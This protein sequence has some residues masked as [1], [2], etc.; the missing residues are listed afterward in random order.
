MSVTNGEPFGRS[1]ALASAAE[2]SAAAVSSAGIS[3]AGLG[4]AEISG[5]PQFAA[6][7]ATPA[8]WG[9]VA[10]VCL[11]VA[12]VA[13]AQAQPVIAPP[14]QPELPKATAPPQAVA[15]TAEGE[16]GA[17]R[18]ETGLGVV[19][20]FLRDPLTWGPVHVHPRAAYRF[21][22]GNGISYARGFDSTTAIHE[23]D[24]G[25][26]FNLGDRW[27][28]DYAPSLRF[29]SN[30]H[31]RDT[32]NHRVNFGGGVGGDEWSFGLSQSYGQ[33]EES[34]VE[35]ATQTEQETYST[36][37]S[38][39]RS[40]GAKLGMEFDVSQNLRFAPRFTDAMTWSGNGWLDYKVDPRI[41]VG[42]GPGGGYMQMSRGSDMTF[43]SVQ[44]RVSG[45]LSQKLSFQV[46]GGVDIRQF[47]GVDLPDSLSPI[48]SGTLGYA[49]FEHTTLSLTASRTVD[50]SYYADQITE[51]T[52]VSVAVQ[53]RLLKRLSLSVSGGYHLGDYAMSAPGLAVSRRDEYLSLHT[54]LGTALGKRG[55]FAVFY[56]IS[57]NNSNASG[58]GFTSSQ[59]GAEISYRL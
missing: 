42:I 6:T 8:G 15:K 27:H 23:I 32:L 43:E 54:R 5:E 18:E 26:L 16:E 19:R 7:P 58:Y 33:S 20:Q 22:Y 36:L 29:Y 53:Q 59:V 52:S 49:P 37:L 48:Y 47:L 3:G 35:T 28:L 1:G 45:R 9:W 10:G 4:G 44:A 30:D 40:L 25:V 2:M 51:N 41:S 13:G 12:V 21:L 56:Q 39:R 46:S 57:R 31:F 34:L 14:P 38:A 55:G 17:V 24:P 11:G 50:A